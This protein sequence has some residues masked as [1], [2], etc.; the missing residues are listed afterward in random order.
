MF[1][2][3]KLSWEESSASMSAQANV[4]SSF[5]TKRVQNMKMKLIFYCNIFC[6]VSQWVSLIKLSVSVNCA[7]RTFLVQI[8]IY[9]GSIF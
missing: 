7:I 5:V 9:S 4:I 3:E 2:R 6:S 8:V 1:S